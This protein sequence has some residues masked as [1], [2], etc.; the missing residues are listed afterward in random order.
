[1]TGI[2]AVLAFHATARLAGFGG[3]GGLGNPVVSR[4]EQ[5][6]TVLT[7]VLVTLAVLNAVCT[8]WATALD[9]RP[10]AALA[11]AFGAT[12]QQASAGVSAAQA[13]AALPGA[14]LG[15]PLGIALFA[16]AS[17]PGS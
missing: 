10:S 7:V 5:I 12:P 14:L 16:A 4:D 3:S 11:R 9:A 2:V 15:I 13:L 8:A 17:G 1:M 6:L